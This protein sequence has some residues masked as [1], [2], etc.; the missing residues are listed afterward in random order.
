MVLACVPGILAASL[1]LATL[2]LLAVDGHPE[3]LLA[4]VAGAAVPAVLWGA[5]RLIQ[6][7]HIRVRSFKVARLSRVAIRIRAIGSEAVAVGGHARAEVRVRYHPPRLDEARTAAVELR[8]LVST[9]QRLAKEAPETATAAV[10]LTKL[11]RTLEMLTELTKILDSPADSVAIVPA[12]KLANT[13]VHQLSD[14]HKLT[15]SQMR[16]G[17]ADSTYLARLRRAIDDIEHARAIAKDLVED[18]ARSRA[19]ND[20]HGAGDASDLP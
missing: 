13:I 1:V 4:A 15:E 12:R 8:E 3:G 14:V 2:V 11:D 19:E 10:L 17:Q 9:V 20:R 18:L 7:A 5:W 6:L 16:L